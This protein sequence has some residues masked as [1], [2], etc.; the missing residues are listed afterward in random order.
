M[1][2]QEALGFQPSAAAMAAIAEMSI[3]QA[4]LR[5]T[6]RESRRR[7]LLGLAAS[8]VSRVP[9]LGSD[10]V[11]ALRIFQPLTRPSEV[12]CFLLHLPTAGHGCIA[13]QQG[14]VD[15]Q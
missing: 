14:A 15:R 8:C 7:L 11:A 9:L 5:S 13:S 10:T 6:W 4:I 2:L 12:G 1:L 3:Q